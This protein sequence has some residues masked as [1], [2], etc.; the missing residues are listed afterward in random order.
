LV[1]LICGAALAGKWSK[2]FCSVRC[3][4]LN[5][6]KVAQSR[7]RE[8]K[9]G[10]CL[11]CNSVFTANLSKQKFCSASCSAK[12]NNHLFKTKIRYCLNDCG[13]RTG[14][15]S[16]KYCSRKCSLEYREKQKILDWKNGKTS[17]GGKKDTTHDVLSVTIRNY[18]LKKFDFK[19]SQC[20]WGKIRPINGKIPIQVHHVDGNSSNNK[21]SN[22]IVLCPNCHSLTE[23]YGSLNKGRGRKYRRRS[24]Y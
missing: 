2:K 22:L 13:N 16:K 5:A 18:I 24:Y 8:I 10:T 4:A 15:N 9:Y 11:F 17:G 12:Y 7:P 6:S 19:C 23:T 3:S 1:C 20:G 21:E 14:K